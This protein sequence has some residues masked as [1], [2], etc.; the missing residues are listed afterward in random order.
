[1]FTFLRA[2]NEMRDGHTC[3]DRNQAWKIATSCLEVKTPNKDDVSEAQE[4]SHH[5]LAKKRCAVFYIIGEVKPIE[6]PNPQQVRDR[7]LHEF[8]CPPCYVSRHNEIQEKL[9]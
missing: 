4:P 2:M 8:L 3:Q 6:L 5:E 9:G 7:K 1:M